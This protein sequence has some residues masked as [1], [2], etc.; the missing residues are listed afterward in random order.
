MN[1]EV[2]EGRQGGKGPPP[3][4]S[5]GVSGNGRQPPSPPTTSYYLLLP[6]TTSYYLLLPPSTVP[7]VG[8]FSSV[9]KG[10]LNGSRLDQQRS[11]KALSEAISTL[12][13]QLINF[14]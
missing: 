9:R 10:G 2:N 14:P 7:S 4:P 11:L 3:P 1:E 5:T 12:L 13:V 6:P 8:A